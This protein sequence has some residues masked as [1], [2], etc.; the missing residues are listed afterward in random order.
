MLTA[1]V[2]C[3]PTHNDS[4][5]IGPVTGTKSSNYNYDY[6]FVYPNRIYLPKNA[7]LTNTHQRNCLCTQIPL[8]MLNWRHMYFFQFLEDTS[9][10]CGA[11]IPLFCTSGDV[12]SGFQS[13]SGFCLKASSHRDDKSI[14][15]CCC[16]CRHKWVQYQFMM[17]TSAVGVMVTN[18]SVHIVTASA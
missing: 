5:S 13:Q 16:Y 7:I 10:F 9:P 18:W 4:A 12:S 8:N 15:L 1:F 3:N 2:S 6:N 14:F 11:L 17:A